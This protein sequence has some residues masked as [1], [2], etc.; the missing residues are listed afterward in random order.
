MLDA[1]ARFNYP[2]GAGALRYIE[3]SADNP[4][5]AIGTMVDPNVLGGFLI[6]IVGFTAPQLVSPQ[7]P[8]PP[9]GGRFLGVDVLALY[10]TYSRGS[11]VGLA[12]G[13]LLIGLLRYRKLLLLA[14]DRRR[15]AAV[16]AA[17]P[18]LRCASRRGHSASGSGDADAPGRVQ[19]CAGTHQ[20]LP[21]VRR[22]LR[23]LARRRSV[24]RRVEPL[25]A[26]G[27][28]HGRDRRG[29]RSSW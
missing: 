18:D 13:M 14:A 15:A 29:W 11:L 25:P 24:R 1:L 19:G 28:D 6:L 17:G 10:L 26:D 23:R 3:D 7:P 21:L 16:P 2:G 27:R 5:R 8:V 12:V 20:P 4:M 9:L 22:R